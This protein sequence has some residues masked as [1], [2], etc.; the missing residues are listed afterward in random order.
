MA[1]IR[2]VLQLVSFLS[3][4][5]VHATVDDD[6]LSFAY[7]ECNNILG[8]FTDG[9][10][11]IENR[12]KLLSKIYSDKEIDY[13]FY[14]FSYDQGADKVNGIGLC[15]GDLNP[16][17]CRGCLKISAALLTDR[18]QDQKEAIGWYDKCMLRYS[19]RSIFGAMETKPN[20]VWC[21]PNSTTVGADAFKT[22]VNDL[23]DRLRIATV[24]GDSSR[25]VAA[26][27]ATVQS[28]NDTVYALLQCTPD[29]SGQSCDQCLSQGF[30]RIAN[31]CDGKKGARYMAPSCSVRYENYT[32]F[33][34]ML[35]QGSEPAPQPPGSSPFPFYSPIR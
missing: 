21:S 20:N 2:V 11:Y 30:S 6:Q 35:G 18:C 15:R 13:G 8:N 26:A 19:N 22:V 14:N 16:D 5:L 33:G 9:S 17:E 1:M 24:S 10:A 12:K 23:L 25:K 27:N 4:R 32:F 31:V 7:H 29:L 3:L 34:A 28:S